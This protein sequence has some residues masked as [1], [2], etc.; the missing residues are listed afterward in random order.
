VLISPMSVRHDGEGDRDQLLTLSLTRAEIR[1]GPE[2]DRTRPFTRDHELL[3]LG[4]YGYPAYWTGPFLWGALPAARPPTQPA[5][6]P[7][8]GRR[9]TEAAVEE[10]GDL[11]LANSDDILGIH[12]HATD[13]EIGHVEDFLSE[14]LTWSIR[15]LV[16]D[17]SNW[18]IGKQVL[19]SPD[20]VDRVDWP[21]GKLH[22]GLERASV[23][24]A[25]EYDGITPPM[26]ET[27][28][29]LYRHH[30]RPPYWTE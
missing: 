14:D 1:Q 12:L 13:G 6:D 16:I 7:P 9:A 15:Y 29:A 24:E 4:H 11:G 19:I 20:W 23:K 3:L 22:I 30:R 21:A 5:A 27:E 18:W 10:T 2:Y 8:A 28:G 26:R 25:P 17:T